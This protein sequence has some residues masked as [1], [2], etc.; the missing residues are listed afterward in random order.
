MKANVSLPMIL[1]IVLLSPWIL[2]GQ[3][4]PGGM[5]GPLG[6]GRS[7]GVI[8]VATGITQGRIITLG[9]RMTPLRKLSHSVSVAGYVDRILVKVGDRVTQG[10][11]LLTIS[12]DSVGETFRPVVL[13]SRISGMVS[14]IFLN[15]KEEVK[16]G[17]PGISI[18]DDSNLV[19]RSALSDRDAQALRAL[20]KISITGK[21][22]EGKTYFGSLDQVS[23]EPDYTTGLFTLSMDF[24][25]QDGLFFGTVVFV[26]ITAEKP[27]GI[28][29]KKT[30]ILQ[31]GP[32][33]FIWVLDKENKL[34]RRP[35]TLGTPNDDKIPVIRGLVAGERY[36]GKISGKE[37]E[38][39]S[40]RE[41]IQANLGGTPGNAPTSN[42]TRETRGN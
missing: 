15:E 42:P 27:T 18:I 38:G 39:M 2:W 4:G 5:G 26:D 40:T 25:K 29:V 28:E 20:G 9:G 17:S 10:Q 1:T 34:R 35:V 37:K 22:P 16:P 32:Q 33:T 24:P 21:T 41:L 31:E 7:N 30:A 13:E 36:V 14:E 8:E 19:L 23:A 6:G 12:R 3:Q 11:S